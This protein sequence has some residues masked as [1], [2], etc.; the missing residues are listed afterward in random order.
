MAIAPN[1]HEFVRSELICTY[2]LNGI[3]HRVERMIY[4]GYE[5][6]CTLTFPANY[7]ETIT[8]FTLPSPP[9]IL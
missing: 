1:P 8:T 7:L 4:V 3:F 5:N 2:T 9:K 6:V